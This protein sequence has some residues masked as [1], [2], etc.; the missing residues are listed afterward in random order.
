M[1][2]KINTRKGLLTQIFI[3]RTLIRKSLPWLNVKLSEFD[4]KCTDS[5]YINSDRCNVEFGEIL[6]IIK[7]LYVSEIITVKQFNRI[8]NHL[9]KS[10]TTEEPKNEHKSGR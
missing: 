7:F 9:K 5:N 10:M 4:S 2:T 8:V 6:G 3:E 1:K